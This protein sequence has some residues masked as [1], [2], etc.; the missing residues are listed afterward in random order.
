MEAMPKRHLQP[1]EN[2]CQAWRDKMQVIC[3]KLGTGF[4]FA[5]VGGRGTGK[6]QMAVKI[7]RRNSDL[8]LKSLYTKSME[9]FMT[10]RSGYDGGRDE[11]KQIL[12]FLRPNL[13]IIDEAHERGHTEWEDRVLTYIL[14]KRYDAM[15]DTLIISNQLVDEF[16]KTIGPSITSR[17]VETGGIIVCEWESFR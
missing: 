7:S 10:I 11:I 17:L 12:P 2:T 13:L 15:K 5:L 9:I 16:T 3:N 4:I 6:T 14:D 1:L 8:E